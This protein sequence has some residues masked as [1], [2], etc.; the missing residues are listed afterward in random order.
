MRFN[1]LIRPRAFMLEARIYRSRD[2]IGSR[3]GS[4]IAEHFEGFADRRF[5]RR[6]R[7]A[8][9]MAAMDFV[10]VCGNIPVGGAARV[11]DRSGIHWKDDS[12]ALD[13]RRA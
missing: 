4:W 2:S 5:I 9:C 12:D 3:D 6:V 1:A 13:V 8:D 11:L 10:A 7:V